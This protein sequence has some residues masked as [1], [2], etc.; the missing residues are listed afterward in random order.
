[1]MRAL[2]LTAASLALMPSVASAQDVVMR[3]PLPGVA[4]GAGTGQTGS[5]PTDPGTGTGGDTGDGT[6]T[7][8]G[9]GDGEG[10]GDDTGPAFARYSYCSEGTQINTCFSFD[11]PAFAQMPDATSCATRQSDAK[12]AVVK[13]MSATL[14]GNPDALVP[15]GDPLRDLGC[16]APPVTTGHGW[17]C[18]DENGPVEVACYL[19][20]K[21][22]NAILGMTNPSACDTPNAEGFGET[23]SYVGLN[24]PAY[25]GSCITPVY[26]WK[27]SCGYVGTPYTYQLYTSTGTCFGLNTKTGLVTPVD[28][29]NCTM[30][31]G[32]DAQTVGA[33]A[34]AGL[35]P[36][37]RA[38]SQWGPDGRECRGSNAMDSRRLLRSDVTSQ[39]SPPD[40]EGRCTAVRTLAWQVLCRNDATGV[41][42]T[43]ISQCSGQMAEWDKEIAAS[44]PP[45]G[46]LSA[47]HLDTVPT[48][49]AFQ[50]QFSIT[51]P[52]TCG[53]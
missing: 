44:I 51:Y 30:D 3:R 45:G 8:G 14:L 52:T 11:G 28:V 50:R 21:D 43:N 49:N 2:L 47:D 1:M 36:G 39:T 32:Y 34:A 7:S 46:S 10:G 4:T 16:I 38:E 12:R 53:T 27:R 23:L 26:G 5:G 33:L 25:D 40:A 13:Q 48:A 19:V 42:A 37:G 18:T 9:T 17:K 35:F 31:K 6:G 24:A 20:D 29:G 22:Q 41:Y 15:A